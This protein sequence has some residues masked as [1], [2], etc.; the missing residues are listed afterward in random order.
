MLLLGTTQSKPLKNVV[1]RQILAMRVSHGPLAIG[2]AQPPLLLVVTQSNSPSI[3]DHCSSRL[4]TLLPVQEML[5]NLFVFFSI[6]QQTSFCPQTDEFILC[7]FFSFH[8]ETKKPTAQHL[9]CKAG[10]QFILNDFIFG[11]VLF[12]FSYVLDF[13]P[14]SQLFSLIFSL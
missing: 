3:A 7:L 6:F 13:S 10:S 14:K 2:R 5:K 12:W 1:D 4:L 8:W 9:P 11:F